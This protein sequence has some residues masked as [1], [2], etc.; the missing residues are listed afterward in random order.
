MIEN[1]FL[2]PGRKENWTVNYTGIQKFLIIQLKILRHL[3]NL[4]WYTGVILFIKIVSVHD[5]PS[6]VLSL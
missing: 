4:D 5:L 2:D 6:K 1:C 3:L